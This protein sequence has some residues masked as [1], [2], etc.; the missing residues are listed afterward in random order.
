MSNSGIISEPIKD[1]AVPGATPTPHLNRRAEFDA[2][3]TGYAP[4]P[5]TL[6]ILA[7]TTIVT[8]TAPSATGRNTIINAL[9]KTGRYH[10]IIS[11]TTRP[12]R[13]NN[14][15]LEQDGVEYYFRTE[16]QVLADIKA[17]RFVE[18][19]VIHSQQV[20]GTSVR[21][22][23][24][25]AKEGK[26]SI[27]DVDI[28]GGIHIAALI[29]SSITICLL[30][31]SFNEWLSRIKGRGAMKPSELHNRMKG[32]VKVFRLALAN[33]HFVFVINDKLEDAIKVV[34]DIAT[35]GIHHADDERAARKL[36]EGLYGDTVAYLAAHTS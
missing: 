8:L 35:K 24:R 7:K 23:E 1:L 20:S 2:A 15:I 30:P 13:S 36:A 17:G 21:E 12:P 26:I 6:R 28:E 16:E 34:D 25:A 3:L 31:P 22:I 33:D 4:S 29:P 27:A 14:G 18:A 19:E 10:F 5:E 11:D 9:V 32:A